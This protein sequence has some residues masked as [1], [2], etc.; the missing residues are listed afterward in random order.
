LLFNPF[1]GRRHQRFSSAAKRRNANELSTS[2][3]VSEQ[4]GPHGFFSRL[5]FYGGSVRDADSRSSVALW[6]GRERGAQVEALR[7]RRH[8]EDK[9][10]RKIITVWKFFL[11][12]LNKKAKG[13]RQ[14]GIKVVFQKDMKGSETIKGF[15]MNTKV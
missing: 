6:D 8:R 3:G 11:A 12:R 9:L 2:D 14:A 13:A 7:T 15:R 10:S 1:S 4:S 5:R